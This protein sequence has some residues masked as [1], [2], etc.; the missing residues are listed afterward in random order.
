MAVYREKDKKKWT[1]DGRSYYFRIWYT[2][3]YGNKKQK[4]SKLYKVKKEAE[5]AESEFRIKIKI[6]DENDINILFE[7][8]SLEWLQ[9]KKQL[10]KFTTY[11]KIEKLLKKHITSYFKS[12]KLHSIKANNLLSWKEN[13]KAKKNFRSRICK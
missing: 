3:M 13:L 4:Q 10:V 2:D 5:D 1:K 8:V 11:Y 7:A 6:Q 9:Y 12:F